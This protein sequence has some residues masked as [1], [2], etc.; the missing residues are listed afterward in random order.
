[1]I[2]TRYTFV[3]ESRDERSMRIK[4]VGIW[5]RQR[6]GHSSTFFVNRGQWPVLC[7]YHDTTVLTCE[8]R[9][10]QY[11]WYATYMLYNS[12][13]QVLFIYTCVYLSF[14]CFADISMFALNKYFCL[15]SILCLASLL[16][17]EACGFI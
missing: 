12:F 7:M 5:Q 9:C 14:S 15:A 16:A 11:F 3:A 10:L 8:M 2:D 6:Q 13:G 1:L 4:S 17:G